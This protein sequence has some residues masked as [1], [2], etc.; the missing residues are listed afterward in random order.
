MIATKEIEYEETKNQHN[1]IVEANQKFYDY[2]MKFREFY[3]KIETLEA[4]KTRIQA[5]LDDAKLNMQE[6][7][8]EQRGSLLFLC[9]V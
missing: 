4:S 7:V 3:T 6:V 9:L 5:D 1:A 2:A 8:G